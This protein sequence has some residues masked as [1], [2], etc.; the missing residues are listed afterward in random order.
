MI[1]EPH[2]PASAS[3]ARPRLGCVG[4]GW[5]GRH[6]I[7]SLVDADA[8]EIVAVCDV[9]PSV[10]AETATLAPEATQ[11]TRFEQL[12]DLDGLD[13]IV[14]ATPSA[15][16]APQCI[17]A[18]E[19]GLAVFCQKPLARSAAE[20]RRVIEAAAHADR[21][22]GI[23]FSYRHLEAT[24][25]LRRL[26]SAGELGR[27][28]MADLVFHNAYGPDKAWF[29][30][31]ERSGGGCVI[32]LGIHLV[33][34]ALWMFDWPEVEA[35]EA[36]CFR[37]GR[38]LLDCATEIEDA[39]IARLDLA[40]G[41]SVRLACS[42]GLQAGQDC[43]I[44]ASLFGTEGGAAIKNVGGSFHDFVA[45][46]YRGTSRETFIEPP[47]AWGGRAIVDWAIALADDP[48]FDAAAWRAVDVAAA[49]D[50]I[51]GRRDGAGA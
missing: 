41:R 17:A 34:L 21:R 42:W 38:P 7:Q 19:R 8:A 11:Y 5:I 4:T 13:G 33:D 24:R 51:Y 37:H 47:G 26:V 6:R 49:I 1:P 15:Q 39:A 28:F 25:R 45:E 43:V 36:R 12:L 48:G 16:H 23:D 35:V 30:D 22:L 9:E 14:I 29:Y 40:G 18:L 50:R 10:L 44:E 2:A 20:T 32:D 3:R 31:I 46:R 27:V